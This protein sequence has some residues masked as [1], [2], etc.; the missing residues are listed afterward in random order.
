MNG[1]R[2]GL[3]AGILSCAV[4]SSVSGCGHTL[5]LRAG[6]ATLATERLEC[7]I[8]PTEPPANQI[9]LRISAQ[10]TCDVLVLDGEVLVDQLVLTHAHVHRRLNS[11]VWDYFDTPPFVRPA[12][13][14]LLTVEVKGTC[15]DNAAVT[16]AAQCRVP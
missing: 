10:P 13:G 6:P 2:L 15:S 8:A 12:S 16:A 14:T 4:L 3:C 9:Q 1:M 7:N 5:R 11:G